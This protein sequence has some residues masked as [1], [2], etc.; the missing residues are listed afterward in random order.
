MALDMT[1]IRSRMKSTADV[2]TA[3]VPKLRRATVVEAKDIA[4]FLGD[5]DTVESST[6]PPDIEMCSVD[7]QG[8]KGSGKSSLAVGNERAIYAAM[9][10]GSP[11][12]PRVL[13]HIAHVRT[14]NDLERLVDSVLDKY[15]AKYGTKGRFCTFVLDPTIVVVQWML[16]RELDRVN[17]AAEAQHALDKERNRIPL[18]EIFTPFDSIRDVPQSAMTYFP[19]VAELILQMGD[20]FRSFGWG[21][22]TLTHY[23]WGVRYDERGRPAGTWTPDI[24]G[25]SAHIVSKYSDTLLVAEKKVVKQAG[26]RSQVI[27]SANFQRDGG[28]CVG[29]RVPILG[30][31]VFH[32]YA[33]PKTPR[34]YVSMQTLR[35]CYNRARDAWMNQQR[36]F[37]A[38][39][40]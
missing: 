13:A 4:E 19:K 3:E 7:I 31:A 25:S 6:V 28:E 22:W 20:K 38:A 18:S 16:A 39:T 30:D 33:N 21:F 36:E 34:T 9:T 35:E 5:F 14:L 11:I 37:A 24:P 2:A 1:K 15:A 32:D 40:K 10:D 12:Y 8:E 27:Y 23:K 17:A 29:S 26:G